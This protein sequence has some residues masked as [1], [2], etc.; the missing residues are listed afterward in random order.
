M[1]VGVHDSP[2]GMRAVELAALLA[3]EMDIRLQLVAAY[4]GDP[5]GQDH[6]PYHVAGE[7]AAAQA[8]GKAEQRCAEVGARNVSSVA[9]A[10][11]PVTVLLDAVRQE[12]ADLLLVGSHGLAT[13]G[14]MLL[15]SVPDGV[16]RR[17]PCDVLVVHTTTDRWRRL[18]SHRFRHHPSGAGR[19]IMVGVHDT[20]RAM[21]AVDRAAEVA[22]DSGGKLVLVGTYE[23][24]DPA[25]VA[26]ALD[27]LHAEDAFM[28]VGS[29]AIE[30]TLLAAE[31]RVRRSGV[32]AVE[33]L[34]VRGEELSGLLRAADR[35]EP[36]LLVLGNHQM[37][38]RLH[39]MLSSLS[40]EVTRKT[41]THV[42]LVH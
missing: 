5:G 36:D 42:L 19:A 37:S 18:L 31:E 30:D 34:V 28:A 22:L 40:A 33:R 8:L 35:Y 27:A 32:A 26:V 14:G 38:G 41:A 1:V 17:A 29:S 21:R 13:L 6:G 4:R 20:P 16:V 23:P 3:G 12:H 39:N 9:R 2:T 11:R 10:G 15:G 24:N 7:R 25:T